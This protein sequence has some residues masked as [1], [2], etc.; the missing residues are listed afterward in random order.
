MDRF[1]SNTT[2][3]VDKKG[4]VSIPAPFRSILGGQS[5]LHTILSVEHPVAEA[6]G[7]QY[8]AKLKARL[9]QMDPFSEE[10][11]VWSF[12]L[13]GDSDELKI[14]PEGRILLSD[15]IREHTGIENEVAFVGRGYF[16][17]LWEPERF[18]AYRQWAR[19]R[20]REMRRALGKASQQPN[21]LEIRAGYSPPDPEAGGEGQDT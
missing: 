3:R 21:S 20:A 4:R 9:Q 7:P 5:T 14:D 15:N 6:G 16:F 17:Q 10:Y 12:V 1:L 18:R 8:L 19:A 11:E 13:E 2:N